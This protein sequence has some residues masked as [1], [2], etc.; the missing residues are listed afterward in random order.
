MPRQQTDIK[1]RKKSNKEKS[2]KQSTLTKNW[3]P[4]T[5]E[6]IN[7]Q[8]RRQNKEHNNKQQTS[9]KSSTTFLTQSIKTT[10]A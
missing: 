2:I 5:I 8:H 7:N 4:T 1:L 3:P 6:D 9:Q 10:Q